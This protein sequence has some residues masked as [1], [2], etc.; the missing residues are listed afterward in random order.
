MKNDAIKLHS[1]NTFINNFTKPG[2]QPDEILRLDFERFFVV[3]VEEMFHMMKLPIPPTKATIHTIIYLTEGE[4]MMTIGSQSYTIVKNQCMIVPAG[5]V[6]SFSNPDINKG[7]LCSFNDDFPVGKFVRN[8]LLRDFEFLKIWGHP[9][10]AL[11]VE[12][13]G[14]ILRLFERLLAEYA[15]TGL[16]HQDILH[17]YLIALLCELNRAYVT[18]GGGVPT[19]S[20]EIT[21]RFRELLFENIATKHQVSDYASMLHITPNHLNKSVRRVTGKPAIRW[22]METIVLEAKVLLYQSNLSISEIALE[23]GVDDQSYFSRLFKKY[24]GITPMGFR[25]KIEKS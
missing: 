10:I 23:L 17:P 6:F 4:A 9:V 16:L 19:I 25:K 24:E 11:T 7:Y 14:F 20:S 15:L 2:T 1:P 21:N 13:S 8:D 12:S 18:T 3:R 5:Q 22:I